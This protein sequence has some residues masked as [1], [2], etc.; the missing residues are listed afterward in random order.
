MTRKTKSSYEKE[1]KYST[2][3][4]LKDCFLN[5]S[6]E[7]ELEQGNEWYCSNCREHKLAKKVLEIYKAPKILILHLKRFKN[8]G[9]FK[10][11]KNETKVVFPENLDMS[12]Y[13]IDRAPI[14]SYN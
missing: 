8:K 1:D 11:E 7:E 10:K 2:V 3:I 6:E 13:L 14:T 9:V 5:L 4:E 12:P